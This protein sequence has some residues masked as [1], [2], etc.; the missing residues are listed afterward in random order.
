MR[1]VN[2]GKNGVVNTFETLQNIDYGIAAAKGRIKMP[3]IDATAFLEKKP[4]LLLG[5]TFQLAR[6]LAVQKIDLKDCPELYRLLEDGETLED[7]M[8]MPPEHI[9]IR[10]INYHLRAAGKPE[11][12]VKNLGSD[13]Q[14]SQVMYYVLNQLDKQNCPLTHIDEA[15]KLKRAEKMFDNSRAMGVADVVTAPDWNKGNPKVN[16]I[17]VA[18]VFNTKHGLDPLTQEEL[19]KVGM[20]DQDGDREERQFKLWINSLEI[21]DCTVNNLYEDV[22]DGQVL[23]KVIHKIDPTAV[24]WNRVE[25]NPNNEFKK[26]INCTVAFDAMKKMKLKLVG[27]GATDIQQGN[28]KNILAFIWQLMRAH[29]MQIIGNKQDKDLINWGNS[30]PANS[31]RQINSFKDQNLKDSVYLINLCAAIEPRIIDW[32]LVFQ[33]EGLDDEKLALNAKYAISIA[34][35]LGAIIFMVW[36]DALELNAKM[37]TIFVATLYELYE[38][39]R[40]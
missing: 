31:N 15:D 9:L 13:L 12:Q 17:Y 19:D 35:K 11:R 20:L 6:L 37:L 1:A 24:E 30:I 33:G 4:H 3:G 8:K 7:L 27:L 34:R 36:E 18:E 10:W 21:P 32:E 23:L 26:G 5:V 40:K 25:K 22:R 39:S 14:D 29:Y 38:E 2:K 28:K 16:V